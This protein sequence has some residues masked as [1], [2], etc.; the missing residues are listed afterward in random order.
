MSAILLLLIV[1]LALMFGVEEIMGT[2][3]EEVP[4]T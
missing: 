2:S 4:I 3:Q 1:G